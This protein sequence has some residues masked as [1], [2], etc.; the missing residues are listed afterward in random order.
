[1]ATVD[2][3]PGSVA[4]DTFDPT[5][6]A[7]SLFVPQ[8]VF[9]GLYQYS[10]Q[11]KRIALTKTH[12]LSQTMDSMSITRVV[13]SLAENRHPGVLLWRGKDIQSGVPT[14]VGAYFP[15]PL[16]LDQDGRGEKL[17][18]KAGASHC[19]FQLMPH[20]RLFQLARPDI[21]LADLVNADGSALSIEKIAEGDGE[22]L[23]HSKPYSIGGSKK[24][25]GLRVD[26]MSKMVN[27]AG[28]LSS[29]DTGGKFWY[30]ETR[31]SNDDSNGPDVEVTF[32]ADRLDIYSVSGGLDHGATEARNTSLRDQAHYAPY[33][34]EG[35]VTGEALTGRI[36]GFGSSPL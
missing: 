10:T 13:K 25:L 7:I 2:I 28:S 19:L 1:M 35:K 8:P 5:L 4:E 20:F 34:S 30:N 6:G 31:V 12:G 15:G 21:P 33:T 23:C 22:S 11:D 17:A 32:K 29:T 16:W 18:F 14:V 24:D 3:A 27:L 36:Q 9:P 26:P